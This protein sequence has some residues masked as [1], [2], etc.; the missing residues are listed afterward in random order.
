MNYPNNNISS[1][2]LP[3]MN[4]TSTRNRSLS[5]Q[6]QEALE[7]ARKMMEDRKEAENLSSSSDSANVTVSN[8]IQ[9]SS[10]PEG[11]TSEDVAIDRIVNLTTSRLP[12][13]EKKRRLI[14]ESS[15]DDVTLDPEA[16]VSEITSSETP[17]RVENFSSSSSSSSS[18]SFIDDDF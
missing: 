5:P 13:A 9:N 2:I 11:V 6:F 16:E 8:N 18:S 10:I 17:L 14:T 1:N 7:N 3:T 12:E 15:D 4:N